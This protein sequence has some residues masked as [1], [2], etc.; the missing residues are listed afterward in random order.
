MARVVLAPGLAKWLQAPGTDSLETS[1]EVAAATLADAL[2]AVFEQHPRLRG[3]V[4]DEQSHVRRHVAVFV[5]GESI[6]DKSDLTRA[7]TSRSEVYVLQAL[8]G[9]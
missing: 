4:L 9:G 7:L 3:Y 6:R 5:D 1:T 8:S 2:E